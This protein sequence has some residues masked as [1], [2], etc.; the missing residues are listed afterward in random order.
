MSTEKLRAKALLLT[1][2]FPLVSLPTIVLS[3]PGDPATQAQMRGVFESLTVAYSYALDPHKFEAAE[4]RGTIAAALASLANA[5]QQ[6]EKHGNIGDPALGYLQQSLAVDAKLAASRF[7]YLQYGGSRYVLTRMTN[8]CMT[9]HARFQAEADFEF[10]SR[11]LDAI[12]SSQLDPSELATALV[13]VRQ[14]DDAMDAFEAILADSSIAPLVL[15]MGGTFEA[16]LRLSLGV[17]NDAQRPLQAFQTYVQRGDLSG[18]MR[19]LVATWIESLEAIDLDAAN[20]MELETARALIADATLQQR[21]VSDRA[22]LVQLVAAETLVHRFLQRGSADKAA[23]AEAYYLLAI[24]D[25]NVSR[26]YWI[27]ETPYLLELSIRSAPKSDFAQTAY[28]F[29]EEYTVAA[30]A[31]FTMP[32]GTRLDLEEM[33]RMVE[34]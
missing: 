17:A 33:R 8:N 3:Q 13:A 4:N 5:A 21:F 2:L 20:G 28:S 9:C 32:E 25:S 22:D 12:D 24:A 19:E 27:S 26:S 6:I 15:N 18:N 14:F 10:G 30:Y 11:F 7:K 23:L 31:G 29:L 16:Y 1:V 34:E